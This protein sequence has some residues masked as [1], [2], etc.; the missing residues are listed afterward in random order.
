MTTAYDTI[1]L[2]T[3]TVDHGDD[4]DCD[5]ASV[6]V[7]VEVEG[8]CTPGTPASLNGLPENCDPG[9]PAEAEITHVWIVED[10]KHVREL[11][12][13]EYSHVSDVLCESLIE[14][15]GSDAADDCCGYDEPDY[16]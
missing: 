10:G 15:A 2:V 8:D 6:E 5:C 3:C 11:S 1:S 9:E 4:C 16:D 13:G 12:E 7:E 14:A